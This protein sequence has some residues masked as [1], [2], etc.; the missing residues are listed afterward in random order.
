VIQGRDIVCLSSLDW[1]AP[2]GS[3]QQA[4]HRLARTNR[5]LYVD[6]PASLLMPF[7][8]SSRWK[9]WRAVVPLLRQEGENLWTLTPPPLVPF[10][11]KVQI[12]NK[13]RQAIMAKYVRWAIKKLDFADDHIFWTYLPSTVAV[14]DKL[15]PPGAGTPP[16]LIVYHCVDEHSAFPGHVISPKL[17]KSYD[18]ELTRRSDLV[19]T[20]SDNLREPRHK[21][22]PHTYTVLNAAD[23][24]L[25][26]Q[27]LDPDLQIPE[28]MASIPTPRIG[29]VGV[30]DYRLDIDAIETIAKADPTWH[31]VLIG[32][33][34]I[35]HGDVSRLQHT[36][37]VHL[38]GERERHE[39][40]AYLK[41]LSAALIPYRTGELTRNIFPLKLFEYLAA[42]V[43]VIAGGLPEL[44][45]Y[46]GMISLAE[47]KEDYPALVREAIAE[48]SPDKRAARVALAAQNSWEDRIA[49]VSDL[50]EKALQRKHPGPSAT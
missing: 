47:K 34:K 32:P 20:T 50:V 5:V 43:P 46:V 13:A 15:Y 14:L 22:N 39:L 45:R 17:V 36:R 16:S 38:I 25:F 44:K 21:I 23:V 42:G 4:M 29:V 8:M 10:A 33:T 12:A 9:R 41:G 19:I 40:P 3:A 1:D 11:N 28:D 48:D 26:N 37:G 2:W 49:E 24:E 7:V 6:E 18:D 35:G 30:H 27:A 31:V